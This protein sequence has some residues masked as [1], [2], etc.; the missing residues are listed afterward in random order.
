MSYYMCFN[1]FL[2]QFES[3]FLVSLKSSRNSSFFF[4]ILLQTFSSLRFIWQTFFK[5]PIL[6]NSLE[7]LALVW[8]TLVRLCPP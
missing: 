2:K 5:R 7:I 6:L 4:F 8:I 1:S 3:I